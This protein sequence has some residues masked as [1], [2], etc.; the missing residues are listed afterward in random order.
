[1]MMAMDAAVRKPKRTLSM[2]RPER[3][4][5]GGLLREPQDLPSTTA[6]HGNHLHHDH[7][8]GELTLEEYRQQL[9]A[10][11]SNTQDHPDD[12]NDDD[13]EASD[14]EDDWER[15]REKNFA[16][17]QQQQGP[18][19][20]APPGRQRSSRGVDRAKSGV[21]MMSIATNKSGGGM[22]MV[23]GFTNLSDLMSAADDVSGEEHRLATATPTGKPAR[24]GDPSRGVDRNQSNLSIMSELTDLSANIDNLSLYED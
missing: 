15:E 21:S 18:S 23:S 2:T 9:E 11:I 20:R 14:L 19:R 13:G 1:M 16:S 10:Y 22:S 12:D 17:Q 6:E 3:T 24:G 5:S 4:H 8:D 7:A